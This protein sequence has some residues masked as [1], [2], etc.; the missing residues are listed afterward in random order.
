M[1]SEWFSDEEEVEHN[2]L[3]EEQKKAYYEIL[4]A[5][6]AGKNTIPI[7]VSEI[8]IKR[9]RALLRTY[10]IHGMRMPKRDDE[11][12]TGILSRKAR[13]RY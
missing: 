10:H 1:I 3:R 4:N 13:M 6:K 2:K 11:G 7:E 9:W 12:E 8:Y 5:I